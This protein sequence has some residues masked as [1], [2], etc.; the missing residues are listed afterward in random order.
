MDSRLPN[1]QR[2]L[3]NKGTAEAGLLLYTYEAGTTTPKTTYNNTGT[4]N[5][6]PIQIDSNGYIPNG[7]YGSDVYRLILKDSKG[8]TL[9][10]EDNVAVIDFVHNN[11]SGLQGGQDLPTK[12]Y[13]HLSYTDYTKLSSLDTIQSLINIQSISTVELLTKSFLDLAHE[14]IET[15][16]YYNNT[17]VGG[18][19]WK[20]TG[21][22]GTP[23]TTD[24][25]NGVLYD[26]DGN[27]RIIVNNT[28]DIASFGC[29]RD[30]DADAPQNATNLQAAINYTAN[31]NKGLTG[32][33]RY[34]ID[35]KI[36]L[37]SDTKFEAY[38]SHMVVDWVGGAG[39][40]PMGH[41]DNWSVF[42][43]VPNDGAGNEDRTTHT[44]NITVK[45]LSVDFRNTNNVIA[46]Q[47]DRTLQKTRFE[48]C[49]VGY[50]G[51]GCI[52]FFFRETYYSSFSRLHC[53][54]YTIPGSGNY[55]S[56]TIGFFMDGMPNGINSVQIE[57]S[58]I[59]KYE[60]G[61]YWYSDRGSVGSTNQGGLANE[62]RSTTVEN[63]N[64]GI[65]APYGTN[66]FDGFTSLSLQLYI[67]LNNI[68][69]QWEQKAT[70][71]HWDNCRLV[72]GGSILNLVEG[73]HSFDACRDFWKV[74]VTDAKAITDFTN[75]D[76]TRIPTVSVLGNGY[77][78][79]LD[80]EIEKNYGK[81]QNAVISKSS[82]I[83]NFEP[84]RTTAANTG[85]F[86]GLS[87]L[88]GNMFVVDQ[89]RSKLL[90]VTNPQL[91][92]VKEIGIQGF[93]KDV[94]YHDKT[95][96]IYVLYSKGY[97][98]INPESLE[99][100]QDIDL[101]V[102]DVN[103]VTTNK[104]FL[105]FGDNS[106]NKI[107]S[108]DPVT[109]TQID[110]FTVSN[111]IESIA[112]NYA[113]KRIVVVHKLSQKVSFVAVDDNGILTIVGSQIVDL[114]KSPQDVVCFNNNAFIADS[115]GHIQMIDVT[116]G[117]I[118]AYD[119]E[120]AVPTNPYRIALDPEKES[121][122]VLT[123]GSSTFSVVDLNSQVVMESIDIDPT[124]STSD[125]MYNPV[126]KN[127]IVLSDDTANFYQYKCSKHGQSQLKSYTA[128]NLPTYT[129]PETLMMVR[130]DGVIGT[131][132]DHG[133]SW[134]EN[135]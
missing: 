26:A 89:P 112:Y 65:Y 30:S 88:D 13:Y 1:Y 31:N 132:V 14:M 68:D 64:Y 66:E 2:Y 104:D 96:R 67:E 76:P 70:K 130:T 93:S 94:F 28:I 125:C 50:P 36:W 47:I 117:S 15:T 102:T 33:G 108:V 113:A 129:V 7:I 101:G 6:N 106:T 24:F 29:V 63:C 82:H 19:K 27:E 60:Y 116:S 21:N 122:M 105:F 10:D 84:V 20:K 92:I 98:E 51:T 58:V 79:V 134:I 91:E 32:G 61:I 17:S 48:N 97:Q 35:T 114:T 40:A 42:T 128:G 75:T 52:G 123:R 135:G 118:T 8:D 73:V 107:I 49:A 37:P 9:V 34:S 86:I 59:N 77:F 124:I 99:K 90:V 46:F 111:S 131:T 56:G 55:Q 95:D 78:R 72:W 12:E 44:T 81:M 22:T 119:G 4:P 103:A 41:A 80:D 5:T 3:N 43:T 109:N 18:A 74:N 121:L 16:E 25:E 11:S 100:V 62:I 115:T 120:I 53:R 83:D 57:D 71:V 45:N 69:V 126:S 110:D 127:F 54:D 23:G 39:P 133:T 38:D 87:Y 85:D